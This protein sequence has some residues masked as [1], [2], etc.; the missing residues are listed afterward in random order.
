MD[1]LTDIKRVVKTRRSDII[2]GIGV[3]LL[4]LLSFGIGYMTAQEQLKE[5]LRIED[6]GKTQ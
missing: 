1:I 3:F 4:S 2:L 6:Y 5:P